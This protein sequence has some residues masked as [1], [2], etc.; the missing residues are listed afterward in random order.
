MHFEVVQHSAGKKAESEKDFRFGFFLEVFGQ[1]LEIEDF[2]ERGWQRGVA[3]KA[4]RVQKRKFKI[5][6]GAE[7]QKPPNFNFAKLKKFGA[8][9]KFK[10]QTIAKFQEPVSKSKPER[11]ARAEIK[12]LRAPAKMFKKDRIPEQTFQSGQGLVDF[13][14]RLLQ[15]KLRFGIRT[16]NGQRAENKIQ[17]RQTETNFHAVRIFQNEIRK[18]KIQKQ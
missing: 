11:V 16:N 6:G 8:K 17:P 2:G 18:F 15:K 5:E 14:F 3:K 1:E 4:E 13:D 9:K 7:K 10:K 12:I